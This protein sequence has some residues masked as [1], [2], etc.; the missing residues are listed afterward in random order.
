MS[1]ETTFFVGS[2]IAMGIVLAVIW[3]LRKP[4]QAIL[5]ELCGKP[6]RARFWSAFSHVTLFLIPLIAVLSRGTELPFRQSG[7][8]AISEQIKAGMTGLVCSVVTLGVVLSV[9]IARYIASPAGDVQ[10]EGVRRG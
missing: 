7:V 2:A 8:F 3:Y 5:T 6:E 10:A 9:Y 4:L 1:V